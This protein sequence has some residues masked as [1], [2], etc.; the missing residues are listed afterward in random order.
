MRALARAVRP[1]GPS[2][3]TVRADDLRGQS[4]R[5]ASSRTVRADSPHGRS[6]GIGS[7]WFQS[8][9]VSSS[10]FGFGSTGLSVLGHVGVGFDYLRFGWV[11][12]VSVTLESNDWTCLGCI[13]LGC[14]WLGWV[15][16]SWECG[17]VMEVRHLVLGLVGLGWA[18]SEVQWWRFEQ[19][20]PRSNRSSFSKERKILLSLDSLSRTRT[21]AHVF[22]ASLGAR[23]A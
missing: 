12:L 11:G 23:R 9:S 1:C 10:W 8:G 5:T 3:R 13:G 22:R 14:V 15:G 17:S 2:A 7:V 20:H 4:A 21:R 6:A 16:L 19:A 18:R